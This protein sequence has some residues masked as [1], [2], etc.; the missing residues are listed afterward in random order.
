MEVEIRLQTLEGRVPCSGEMEVIPNL[1][2][3]FTLR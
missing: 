1:E 2:K 3:E